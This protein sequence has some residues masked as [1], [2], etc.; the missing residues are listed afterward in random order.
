MDLIFLTFG[1]F[2]VLLHAIVLNY[3]DP[4]NDWSSFCAVRLY[5]YLRLF[6]SLITSSYNWC[7]AV[8][9]VSAV[10]IS[11]RTLGSCVRD[12][13]SPETAFS[14]QYRRR[15][16]CHTPVLTWRP[17]ISG[18]RSTGMERVTAQCHLRAVYLFIPATSE[19]KLFCSSDNCVNLI[20]M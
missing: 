2:K 17:R 20:T 7:I 4:E 6:N 13:F 9:M 14:L 15:G 11:R 1:M 16:S 12:S 10:N 3:S 18:R 19:K 8:F 5:V